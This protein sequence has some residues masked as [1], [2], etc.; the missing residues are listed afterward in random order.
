MPWG[1]NTFAGLPQF[2]SI[3]GAAGDVNCPAGSY[4]TV[5]SIGGASNTFQHQ[6]AGQWIP[7]VDALLYFK[8]GATAPSAI[9]IG[10]ATTTGTEIDSLQVDTDLL[11]NNGSFAITVPLMGVKSNTLWQAGATPLVEVNPTGQA[12]TIRSVSVAGSRG[13]FWLQGASN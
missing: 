11:V 12:V 1:A 2:M 3:Q 8:L 6:Q 7:R 5:L 9:I 10:F 13:I 4:T